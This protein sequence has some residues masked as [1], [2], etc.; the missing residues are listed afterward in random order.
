MRAILLILLVGMHFAAWGT[1]VR[2]F[3]DL[4]YKAAAD[5]AQAG[6]FF[7]VMS[8]E[9]EGQMP[10]IGGYKGV[11]NMMMA[12]NVMNPYYKYTYFSRGR[13]LLQSAI[14]N[15]PGNVELRFLRFCIQTN[16][17][18]FLGYHGE[19]EQDKE[20]IIKEWSNIRDSDLK[21]RIKCYILQSRYCNKKEKGAVV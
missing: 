7:E 5:K 10:I 3:R 13:A 21:E 12:K 16:T 18:F 6:R 17:P 14:G 8:K 4:F 11:A 9:P 19:I 2:E 15:E 1:G 20:L